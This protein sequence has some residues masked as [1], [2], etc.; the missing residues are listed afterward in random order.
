MNA[1]YMA[2][3][4]KE[5]SPAAQIHKTAQD[6]SLDAVTAIG[7]SGDLKTI[8]TAERALLTNELERYGNSVGMKSSLGSA[9][10][11]IKQAEKMHDIAQN[12]DRYREVD[13]LYQRPKNRRRGLPYDEA[14]QF[15][16]AHNTRLLNQDRSRLSETEKKTLSARRTNMR[17]AE[18]AYIA[19]QQKALGQGVQKDK[20]RG[21]EIEL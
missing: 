12:K 8:L 18:K 2:F 7:R 20:Q 10:E 3:E 5:L 16:N 1:E 13:E 11:E 15:F 6:N 4:H 17:I 14:R 21:R 19:L 9:L